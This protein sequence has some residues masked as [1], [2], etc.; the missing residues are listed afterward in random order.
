MTEWLPQS[1]GSRTT[2][3]FE[4]NPKWPEEAIHPETFNSSFFVILHIEP[5]RKPCW[6]FVKID[7]KIYLESENQITSHH[8]RCYHPRQSCLYLLTGFSASTLMPILLGLLFS[9]NHINFWKIRLCHCLVQIPTMASHGREC[10]W[11]PKIISSSSSTDRL[12][13]V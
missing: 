12:T 1:S 11:L 5:L 6:G 8:F 4:R 7:F 9:R 13:Q 2:K 10:Y 3:V